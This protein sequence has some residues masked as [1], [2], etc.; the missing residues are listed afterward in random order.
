MNT[1]Q[2]CSRK[3]IDA[4]TNE[5]NCN[6]NEWN[7]ENIIWQWNNVKWNDESTQNEWMNGWASGRTNRKTIMKMTEDIFVVYG[8]TSTRRDARHTTHSARTQT[9]NWWSFAEKSCVL[10]VN[11]TEQRVNVHISCD[12][13][14][15]YSG[16]QIMLMFVI[17]TWQNSTSIKTVCVLCWVGSVR[18]CWQNACVCLCF[19]IIRCCL[20]FEFSQLCI[21]IIFYVCLLSM[22]NGHFV[23]CGSPMVGARKDVNDK[24]HHFSHLWL[25]RRLCARAF[26]FD[27]VFHC[28]ERQK[29]KKNRKET[30]IE[31]VSFIGISDYRMTKRF[32]LCTNR[33][34]EKKYDR[35][36]YFVVP[37]PFRVFACSFF[38]KVRN[39][40]TFFV[41]IFRILFVCLCA[42]QL[43]LKI[44]LWINSIKIVKCWSE[45]AYGRRNSVEQRILHSHVLAIVQSTQN[46][47]I[48]ADIYRLEREIVVGCWATSHT[49]IELGN[50]LAYT[51]IYLYIVVAYTHPKAMGN[52]CVRAAAAA[53]VE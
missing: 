15:S 12:M 33:E 28:S 38:I 35:I 17:K 3:Q 2:L 48:N 41:T 40:N 21:Y 42:V 52:R 10:L 23:R 36:I 29:E 47:R 27:F 13:Y 53:S 22:P 30:R 50:S 49:R 5:T 39:S 24:T 43:F 8:R 32:F 26:S 14:C 31:R 18:K 34:R 19:G 45:D 6:M 46:N 4:R 16:Q 7:S 37:A 20:L 9:P 1:W 44:S 51:Y 25:L 11:T